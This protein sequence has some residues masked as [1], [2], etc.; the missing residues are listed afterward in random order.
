M[1]LA[2][3]LS[4]ACTGWAKYDEIGKLLDYG[5]IIPDNKIHHFLKIKFVVNELAGHI[6]EA[7][8]L[9]VEGI[10]LNTFT[11]GFHNVTGFEL[12]ARLSGAVINSYLQNHDVIPTVYKATEARKLVGV[13]SSSQKA[14]IQLWVI[15]TFKVGEIGK[16]IDLDDFDALIDSAYAE[17]NSKVIKRPAF[18]AR[19]DKISKMIEEATGIGEDIADAILLGR[20][21]VEGKRINS[22]NT[23]IE[24]PLS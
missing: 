7:D 3:D 15:E 24:Q 11:G 10:F 4:T 12:L 9:V 2:L 8:N 20:A 23:D 21:Y 19:M 14:E 1:I 18:K 13:K 16:D 22:N 5:R 6:L 17:L